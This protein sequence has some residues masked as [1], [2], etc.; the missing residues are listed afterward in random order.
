MAFRTT[1]TKTEALAWL[2]SQLRWEHVLD[3]LRTARRA[4]PAPARRAA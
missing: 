4:T 3:E 1:E 2:A